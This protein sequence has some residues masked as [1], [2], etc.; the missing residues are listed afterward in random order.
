MYLH[1]GNGDIVNNEDIIGIFDMDTATISSVS[2]QFLSSA[3]QKK[4]IRYGDSDIPKSFIVC[5]EEK[6]TQKIV[7]SR[8]SSAALKLRTIHFL[9][10]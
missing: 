3:E 1:I 5:A 2:R 7:F 8:I 4:E 6:K 9:T 10:E